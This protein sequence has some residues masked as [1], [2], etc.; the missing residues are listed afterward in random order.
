METEEKVRR[1]SR[2]APFQHGPASDVHNTMFCK[3]CHGILK[4]LHGGGRGLKQN[5]TDQH[6]QTEVW[7]L[8]AGLFSPR[9]PLISVWGWAWTRYHSGMALKINEQF[10]LSFW[11]R[12]F[13]SSL[14]SPK[15]CIF[16]QARWPLG[17]SQQPHLSASA[18]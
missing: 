18:V 5:L 2:K 17:S 6:P 12:S 10:L 1:H 4:I 7:G 15:P 9:S 11:Q 16:T 13:C 3:I 8:G 14:G